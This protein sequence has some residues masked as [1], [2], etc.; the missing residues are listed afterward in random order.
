MKFLPLACLTIALQ[1]GPLCAQSTCV[2]VGTLTL[3]GLTGARS[4]R[5]QAMDGAGQLLDES[6]KATSVAKGEWALPLGGVTT[7]WYLT[8][9]ER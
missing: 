2:L 5:M 4:V 8:E 9:V 6:V 7:T 1:A 3:R